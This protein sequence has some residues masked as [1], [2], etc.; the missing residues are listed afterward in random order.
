MKAAVG[1]TIAH[2][3][4]LGDT[5]KGGTAMVCS[6]TCRAYN[7]DMTRV[8]YQVID[9]EGKPISE[10]HFITDDATDEDTCQAAIEDAK[11]T[12][13]NRGWF[14]VSAYLG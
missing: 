11:A 10:E 3:T 7:P 1:I 9:D 12:L 4:M 6:V 2:V 13:K 14:R 5:V 8:S